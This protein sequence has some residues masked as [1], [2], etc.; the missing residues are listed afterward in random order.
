MIPIVDA[1]NNLTN[2]QLRLWARNQ[3]NK[4]RERDSLR[5]LDESSDQEQLPSLLALSDISSLPS[6][7][8]FKTEMF[9]KRF[10]LPPAQLSEDSVR[11]ITSWTNQWLSRMANRDKYEI[12]EKKRKYLPIEKMFIN[13]A[14]NQ[15]SKGQLR[16]WLRNLLEQWNWNSVPISEVPE[17][18]RKK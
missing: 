4:L 15:L 9:P 5:N 7:F 6:K 11:E 1:F 2:V 8:H 12:D 18:P 14:F 17:A 16:Y 13:L 10:L 3:V